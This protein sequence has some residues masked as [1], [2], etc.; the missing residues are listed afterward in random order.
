MRPWSRCSAASRRIGAYSMRTRRG[1]LVA[2]DRRSRAG[3]RHARPARARH[4][5]SR[6]PRRQSTGPA[7]G[8]EF[9]SLSAYDQARRCAALDAASGLGTA[10]RHRRRLL[11]RHGGAGLRRAL[12]GRASGRIVVL[13]A[14]DRTHPMAT[15]WRSVQRQ[16]V[17]VAHLRR[18]DAADGLEAG[19]RAGHGHLSQPARNSPR[20]SRA[21]R[22]RSEDRFVFPVEEYLFARGDDYVQHYRPSRSCACRESIDLHRGGCDAAS[23]CRRR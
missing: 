18:G 8:S 6:R 23:R 2:G 21:R 20:A 4:R 15:A 16:I 7:D 10:A 22:T 13:S 9:P 3:A 1:G 12:S 17:R 19:A 14:A 5:L 11:R